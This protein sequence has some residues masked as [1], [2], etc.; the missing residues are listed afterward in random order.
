[1]REHIE[2]I[3]F[4]QY[5]CGASSKVLTNPTTSA[6]QELEPRIGERPSSYPLSYV[7]GNRIRESP[8]DDN[9]FQP[10]QSFSAGTS[11]TVV[12][13]GERSA[14]Y[15]KLGRA[16]I[17]SIYFVQCKCEASGKVL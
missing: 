4:V 3:Y 1:L 15:S 11:A 10:F 13:L 16:Y 9:L 7:N 12:S 14:V 2:S 17:E 8:T 5:K 6:A